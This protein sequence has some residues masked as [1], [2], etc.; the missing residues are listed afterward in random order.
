M[1]YVKKSTKKLCL[2]LAVA[3]LIS[4]ISGCAKGKQTDG[5]ELTHHVW[6][7][8]FTVRADQDEVFSAASDYIQEKINATVEF[9]PISFGDYATK[10]QVVDASQEAYDIAFAS[11]WLNNYYN[12]VNKGCYLALDDL[13]PDYAPYTFQ[14]MVKPEIWDGVRINGKIYGV[15]NQQ[16]F[17]ATPVLFVPK[18]NEE[19]LG[20]KA[21]DLTTLPALGDYLR[22]VKEATDKYVGS[23]FAWSEWAP[24]VGIE[25]FMGSGVP[26][27]IYFNREGR[28]TVF[29]QYASEEYIEY[30]N[31]KRAWCLE[32]ITSPVI[33]ESTERYS[34]ALQEKDDPIAS[35]ASAVTGTIFSAGTPADILRDWHVDCDYVQ[36]LDTPIIT[37]KAITSTLNVISTTSA[38]PERALMILDLVNSDPDLMNLMSF[39]IE[40]KNYKKVGENRIEQ[41]EGAEYVTANWAFG[42][43]FNTYVYGQQPDNMQA[44]DAET[45]RSGRIS[46]IFGFTPDLTEIKIELSNCSAVTGEYIN[47]LN[48]GVA[49]VDE[50][51]TKFMNKLKA[52]GCDTIIENLQKQL[53]AWFDNQK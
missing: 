17:A 8:P 32:G 13:L 46:P 6:Y 28:P 51:Y 7:L 22:K 27:A 16:V 49:D 38:R 37:T 39:G 2:L 14:K 11:N 52:A 21:E 25:E 50:I 24:A 15:I 1:K 35:M 3:M 44:L 20:V 36:L 19:A 26:G 47:T 31:T 34:T 41:I 23:S 40:G 30:I 43:V 53:D 42:N 5:E 18:K 10:M 12:N 4:T 45:N 33:P 29:N 48:Y 9:I